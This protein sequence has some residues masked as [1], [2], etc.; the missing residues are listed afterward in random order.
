MTISENQKFPNDPSNLSPALASMIAQI[1]MP[2][3]YARIMRDCV[4]SVNI[5][6]KATIRH[7][8]K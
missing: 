3:Q 1:T 4:E 6:C 7:I 2:N 8:D 5:K